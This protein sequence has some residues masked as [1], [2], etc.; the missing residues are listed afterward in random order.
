MKETDRIRDLI[1][2]GD[3]EA[4]VKAFADLTKGKFPDWEH[5]ATLLSSEYAVWKR[6][7]LTGLKPREEELQDI[8]YRILEIL[9]SIAETDKAQSSS[10]FSTIPFSQPRRRPAILYSLLIVL[11]VVLFFFLKTSGRL[12]PEAGPAS[13]KI[14]HKTDLPLAMDSLPAKEMASNPA[15][16][17]PYEEGKNGK[18]NFTANSLAERTTQNTGN[19]SSTRPSNKL[20]TV[21]S[22]VFWMG[23]RYDETWDNPFHYVQLS[24]FQIG[25]HEV[26]NDQYCAF[27]NNK[28]PDAE[29]LKNWID[30]DGQSS[31]GERCR[32]R[33]INDIFTVEQGYSDSPVLFVSWYGA[34]AY[35]KWAGGRLPTEAEWEYAAIS[36]SKENIHGN[37]SGQSTESSLEDIAWYSGNSGRKVHPVKTRM[38]NRLNLYDLS[39]NVA[40]WCADIYTPITVAE[41]KRDTVKN[42]AGPQKNYGD[43]VI[44]GG[45]WQDQAKICQVFY[46][47][48]RDPREKTSYIGFRI[49]K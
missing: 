23:D 44:R 37:Y 9:K 24:S 18:S 26:I 28:K 20:I 12:S 33:Y 42:P 19:T 43:R 47:S 49:A 7:Y 4:A 17:T 21:S 34:Q 30:L 39:G 5:A 45:S 2:A 22:G 13:E 10:T 46:R 32:I 31:S 40:E 11:S 36:R 3:I 8:R 15:I 38:P 1:A 16:K 25:E 14:V 6:R 41:E 48:K 27:L 29:T 35:C